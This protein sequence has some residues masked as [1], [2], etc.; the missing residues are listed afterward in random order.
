MGTLW[1][2][3]R[4]GM[5][6]LRRSPLTA[7]AAL[8][9]LALGIGANCAIFSVVNGVLL[10]P[11][12]YPDPDRIV[13]VRESNPG[14]GFPTFSVA[15]QNFLDWRQQNR[16][17][18]ALAAMDSASVS[19]TGRGEPQKLRAA[20]V[21]AEFWQVF[22]VARLPG[23]VGRVFTAAE[24]T[25]ANHR[26]VVLADG[27][28]R[29]RFG[30]DPA[31]VG[32][33]LTLDGESYTVV[34]VAPP[35]FQF[36]SRRDLWLPLAVDPAKADRANH[37]YLVAGRLRPGASLASATTEMVGLAGRLARLFPA[38]NEGWTV[39]LIGLK[40][41]IVQP[42]RPALL[43]LV[44]AVAAVLL[45]ACLNVANLL[46]VRMAARERELAVRT[47]LG[48]SRGRL[49]RQVLTESVLLALGG[50]LL[51][52]LLAIWG[53]H[54]LVALGGSKIPRADSIAVDW[55]ALAFTLGV[56]V[57]T[58]LFCGLVPAL[59]SSGR[60][61]HDSLKEGGRAVAGG[62]RGR[63]ARQA[64]VLSEVAVALV[65][66]V[67][68]GLLIK[69][70]SRLQSL[71]PGFRSQGVL[72]L[73]L[74]PAELRYREPKQQL[75]FYRELLA[76]VG[77]LPGVDQAGTAYPLPLGNDV[78][79]LNFAVGDRPYPRPQDAPAANVRWVSPGFFRA[80]GV[81]LLKG[82]VFDDHDTDTTTPVAVLNRTLANKLW[83]G[84]EAL[85]QR[86]TLDDPH[87]P[88]VRWMTVVGVVGD[89]RHESLDE[90]PGDEI[91]TA[92][93]QSPMLN[94]TLVVHTAGDPQKLATPIRR[95]VQDLDRD[96]PVEQ[97]QTMDEVV[98][99]SLAS[100]RFNTVLLG[101]FAGL[102]LVLAAVGV[103]GVVSYTVD[104]RTHEIGIR[105]ALGAHRDDVLGLVLRQGM[106][107]VLIGLGLGLAGAFAATRQLASL[108]YGVSTNDPWTF[109]IVALVLAA[110]AF[111]ANFLPA[112]RATRIDP[113]IALRQE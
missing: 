18:T 94:G 79:I 68:A 110:V 45:I 35:R 86:L 21:S 43:V 92:Q 98:A 74:S 10:E 66:L 37:N 1:S 39:R 97:A 11:L 84:G 32:R 78:M 58:G 106:I 55:K 76:R 109:A 95:I 30:A 29:R 38:T 73:A 77:R 24:D 28:W 23:G 44:A 49:V 26:V 57:G 19:L 105:M 90:D 2:D 53:V 47:A 108:V 41:Q 102:A 99:A 56:A 33:S 22:G 4:F 63:L 17:F 104:Q 62:A 112:R 46:L 36:P 16:S 69:S 6:S 75:A 48:A 72:T 3:V 87:Q 8:L 42:I 61:L 85:H 13:L 25:P 70:F 113:L 111:A 103:Y 9:A 80:L 14:M 20:T 91:Y 82:R 83:P 71:D 51:G 89:V 107:L 93:L 50:S 101:L 15:S 100:N 96:L 52:L 59:Q 64:L 81:P 7:G 88:P 12:P 40:E 67:A 34:G 65:L 60:H 27:F 31:I 5:R 54:A